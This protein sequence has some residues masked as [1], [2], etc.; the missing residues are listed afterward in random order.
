MK[1]NAVYRAYL[2]TGLVFG[3]LSTVAV[4]GLI[5]SIIEAAS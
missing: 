4:V 3:A 5:V 2:T 1:L